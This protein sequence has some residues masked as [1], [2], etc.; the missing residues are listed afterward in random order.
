LKEFLDG[1][2]MASLDEANDEVE[3]GDLAASIYIPAN[4]SAQASMGQ[5]VT[6]DVYSDSGRSIGSSV[7][8]SIINSLTNGMNTVLVGQG[9]GPT[10]LNEIGTALGSDQTALDEASARFNGQTSELRSG[11]EN[12]PIA[13]EQVSLTGKVRTFDSLQYFAPSMAILFMTFAMGTSGKSIILEQNHWTLQRILTTQ[14][15]R[16]VF[17]A[18][19][20]LGA[21]GMG[22]VQMGLLISATSLVALLLGRDTAVWGTNM[23]GLLL[24]VF[25]VV[26][27]GTG[28]GLVIAA[29]SRT[30]SQA[31]LYSTL[32]MLVM[33]ML[34]G[35]F[36]QIENL[37]KVIA[38]LPKLTL[39]YWGIQGFVELS[40]RQATLS[41][42]SLHLGML[43]L[44]G[45]VLSVISLWRF[46][47]R[48]EM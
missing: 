25:A 19:K 18:G 8:A 48:L 38:W 9:V 39:N 10:Y 42:I 6:L 45:G 23:P 31:D 15:P 28:L 27:A 33:G 24:M 4:A 44:I 26:F 32:I 14:T 40:Y 7:V 36:L 5:S 34:G 46:N 37:P 13:L 43:A 47:R 21:L 20:L 3:N 30:A 11:V 1:K 16:W 17:I 22:L 35:S 29:F 41:E 2:T 12:P